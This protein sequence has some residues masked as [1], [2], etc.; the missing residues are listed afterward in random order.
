MRFLHAIATVAVTFLL[1]LTTAVPQSSN[2]SSGCVADPTVLDSLAG[3]F[4]IRVLA[5]DLEGK[6]NLQVSSFLT[7]RDWY[8][9]NYRV[10]QEA[11]IG[12]ANRPGSVFMLE[13]KRLYLIDVLFDQPAYYVLPQWDR[14]YEGRRGILWASDVGADGLVDITAT[15]ACDDFGNSFLRLGGNDGEFMMNNKTIL[16]ECSLSCITIGDSLH[17]HHSSGK[18]EFLVSQ[19]S[20]PYLVTIYNGTEPPFGELE[21]FINFLACAGTRTLI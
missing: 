16:P 14:S 19:G 6:I 20:G 10:M 9:D 1:P 2:A 13:N 4:S 5:P 21:H 7:V 18:N 3:K 12:I 11:Y 15:G 17:L 8:L